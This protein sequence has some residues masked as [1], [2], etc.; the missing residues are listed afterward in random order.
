M[1]DTRLV[2]F[3]CEPLGYVAMPHTENMKA[4][5]AVLMTAAAW[6]SKEK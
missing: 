6:V 1:D 2:D 3:F 5:R 4:V